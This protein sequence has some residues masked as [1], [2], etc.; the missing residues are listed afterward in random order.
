MWLLDSLCLKSKQ[1]EKYFSKFGDNRCSLKCEPKA[2]KF[3][4]DKFVDCLS[5]NKVKVGFTSS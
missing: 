4:L 2:D 5:K 1:T 3:L